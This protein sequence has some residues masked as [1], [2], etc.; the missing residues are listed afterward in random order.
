MLTTEDQGTLGDYG[1]LIRRQWLLLVGG[2]I[3]GLLLGI[4]GIAY[5]P[6]SFSSTT[7]VIVLPTGDDTNV[8][9]GRTTAEINLD[10]EAQIVTSLVVGEKAADLL[11][12]DTDP[13]ELAKQ[14]EV[15]VPAN[16]SVLNIGFTAGSAEE[17]Q[18]GAEAFATAYLENRKALATQRLSTKAAALRAKISS[19]NDELKKVNQ[20]LDNSPSSQNNFLNT[21]RNLLVQQIRSNTSSLSPLLTQEVTPGDVITEAQL[22]TRPSGL[23]RS[24]I[25]ASGLFAGLLVGAFAAL[26][27]DRADHRLRTRRDLRRLGFDVL[28][29]KF[30]LPSPAE[31]IRHRHPQD[32]ALRQ[33]RNAL[34]ARLPHHRGSL[35]VAS[36][37]PDVS[38]A[39][40]AA[41]LAVTFARSGVR[42]A[43]LCS[44]THSDIVSGASLV[45]DSLPTLADVLRSGTAPSEALHE[46]A[47][48]PHLWVMAPGADGGLFS[49]LL[50]T[51]AMAPVL[52]ELESQV[53]VVV[54][55]VAPTA[56]NADAQTVVTATQGLVLVAMAG[57]T[58]SDDVVEAAE[59]MDHVK[60]N[61]L[62]AILVTGDRATRRRSSSRRHR[63]AAQDVKH[64]AKRTESP[65]A[66]Q[67][68]TRD[69]SAAAHSENDPGNE[70]PVPSAAP[71]EALKVDQGVHTGDEE[72]VST[73][74]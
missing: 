71:G 73:R 30:E 53:E 10:T 21:Q 31:V 14:V 62:G 11:N 51:N 69:Q 68:L 47:G 19:L 66:P 36:A 63:Q 38:G 61:M 65:E 39:A 64:L 46:V 45:D 59:Q 56:V 70:A 50:Q 4:A 55:D 41:S 12:T 37:S 58:T 6:E 49:E 74:Q 20:S 2:A 27:R 22:P 54:L 33:C 16:T 52:A 26:V 40:A 44:N 29:S 42:T 5:A 8:T 32:E 3:L 23:S 72:N 24:L 67:G 43:F 7:S 60:A 35:V 25:L 28:V 57:V 18:A 48:V 9:N 34:L 13:R 17:A 15:T 1:A